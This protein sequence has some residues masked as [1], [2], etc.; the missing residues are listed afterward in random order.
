[1]RNCQTVMLRVQTTDLT[2]V[3]PASSS[4]NAKI[5]N[6]FCNPPWQL[7]QTQATIKV[8]AVYNSLDECERVYYSDLFPSLNP[9][10][11]SS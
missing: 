9:R 10:E 7:T 2:F 11:I 6:L 4:R 1:M 3:A 5:N 8:Y